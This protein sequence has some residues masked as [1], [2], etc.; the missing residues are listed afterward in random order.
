MQRAFSAALEEYLRSL[1]FEKYE[2]LYNRV[3][4][5]LISI[6]GWWTIRASPS[7]AR[8]RAWRSDGGNP[9]AWGGDA[10]MNLMEMLPRAAYHDEAHVGDFQGAVGRQMGRRRSGAGR[11]DEAGAAR[12]GDLGHDGL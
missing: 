9:R 5:L 7:T 6:D 3:G 2:V 8:P 1:A 10:H 4:A 12:H 11:P